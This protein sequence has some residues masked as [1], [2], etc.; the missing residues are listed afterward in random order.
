MD[1]EECN[2]QQ[3]LLF[4]MVEAAGP[5]SR[6]LSDTT[7]RSNVTNLI[8]RLALL[9]SMWHINFCQQRIWIMSC[10]ENKLDD[11]LS[12][13]SHQSAPVRVDD[14]ICNDLFE[15]RPGR[16]QPERE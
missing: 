10:L 1:T 9:A 2:S 13:G 15:G 7:Q 16:P 11:R 4:H 12:S 6:I 14:S 8:L 5:V 3:Q